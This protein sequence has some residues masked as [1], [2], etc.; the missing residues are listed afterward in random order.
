MSTKQKE[1]NEN[2][3][4]FAYNFAFRNLYEGKSIFVRHFD[5]DTPKALIN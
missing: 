2:Y 4:L 3:L 1:G 5:G